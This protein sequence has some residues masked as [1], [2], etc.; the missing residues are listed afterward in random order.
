MLSRSL[1][2]TVYLIIKCIVRVRLAKN[3]E[4]TRIRVP[5]KKSQ[6]ITITIC[7]DYRRIMPTTHTSR[8][9][10]RSRNIF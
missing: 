9:C 1:L 8:G 4:W 6:N 7:K 3:D 10:Q 2:K 5:V